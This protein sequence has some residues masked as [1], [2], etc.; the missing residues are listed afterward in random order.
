MTETNCPEIHFILRREPDL[1]PQMRWWKEDQLRSRVR[2]QHHKA[3]GGKE[4]GRDVRSG[5]S[6][7][8]PV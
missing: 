1:G 5:I 3:E 7:T 2:S 6:K 4:G 8:P